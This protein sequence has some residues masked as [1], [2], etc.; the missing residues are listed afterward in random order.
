[1]KCFRLALAGAG[2]YHRPPRTRR[3]DLGRRGHWLKAD[4]A[5]G[6]HPAHAPWLGCDP[7]HARR[8]LPSR[9]S[10]KLCRYRHH[11]GAVSSYYTDQGRKKPVPSSSLPLA[12]PARAVRG[13]RCCPACPPCLKM[14]DGY[15]MGYRSFKFFPAEVAGG[16]DALKAFSGPFPD[17]VFCPNGA[18]AST[19]PGTT[20]RCPAS[21]P[22]AAPG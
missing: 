10:R 5:I 3:V 7:Q 13:C 8:P 1:M 15:A 12:A 6:S 21:P 16:V 19:P 20:W 2:D 9:M 18:F 22:S 14:M 17:V 11:R 4:P